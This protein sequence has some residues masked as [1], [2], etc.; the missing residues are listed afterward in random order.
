MTDTWIQGL[1]E[2][3]QAM[4]CNHG[5]AGFCVSLRAKFRTSRR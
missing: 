1:K 5:A 4:S 2:T 3:N